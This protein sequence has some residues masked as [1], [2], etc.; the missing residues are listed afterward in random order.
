MLY[1]ADFVADPKNLMVQNAAHALDFST[2]LTNREVMIADNHVFNTKIPIESMVTNQKSSGRCWIFAALNVFRVE[3]M[4]KYNLEEFEL[5]QGYLFFWDKFEKSNCKFSLSA[6]VIHFFFFS[7]QGLRLE[8]PRVNKLRA[9]PRNTQF[10]C[11]QVIFLHHFETGV[12]RHPFASSLPQFRPF[13]FILPS[14]W[15]WLVEE[16]W[17][18]LFAKQVGETYT[19]HIPP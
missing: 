17:R 8:G 10:L 6:V 19:L 13:G 18:V 5:S 3:V 1:S 14:F 12:S 7:V 9:V 15:A 4:K 2:L 16:D 11:D